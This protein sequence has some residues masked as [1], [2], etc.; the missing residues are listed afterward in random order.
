M[1][2]QPPVSSPGGRKDDAG[3]ARYDLVPPEAIDA[4][5]TVLTFGSKKYGDR[6]WEQG[7]AWSR[8]FAALMRHAWA[9]W[10]GEQTDPETGYSHLWHAMCCVAFLIA[11]EARKSGQDDRWRVP[12]EDRP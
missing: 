6:N 4:L 7:M 12:H 5:A 1:T 9:W 8:P 10:R 2:A 11:Y 3:K